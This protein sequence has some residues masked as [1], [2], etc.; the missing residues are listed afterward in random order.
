MDNKSI[1]FVNLQVGKVAEDNKELLERLDVLNPANEIKSFRDTAAIIKNLDL[2]ISIDTS[3]AHLAG[4]LGAEVWT[5]LSY[6][7][8]WRWFK[9]S[10][11]SPWY[12]SMKLYRQKEF[13]N[14]QE[15]INR[16]RTKLVI[17]G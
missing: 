14:W 17:Y 8:D 2:V 13:N 7:A 3:V 11:S 12:K 16:V 10:E 9:A 6:K 5:L 1:Q 15:L 4:A